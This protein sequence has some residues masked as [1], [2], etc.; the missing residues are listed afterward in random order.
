MRPVRPSTYLP[1]PFVT[2]VVT[3]FDLKCYNAIWT[4]GLTEGFFLDRIERLQT[5]DGWTRLKNYKR[6]E[7]AT[8]STG[9]NT[10]GELIRSSGAQRTDKTPV[11]RSE[12][13]SVDLAANDTTSKRQSEQRPSDDVDAV[14]GKLTDAAIASIVWLKTVLLVQ[15]KRHGKFAVNFVTFF[16]FGRGGEES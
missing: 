16:F 7:A 6:L 11:T 3:V 9:T 12:Q 2:G 10:D 5:V 1:S 13:R 15:L 14:V 4:R 8:L